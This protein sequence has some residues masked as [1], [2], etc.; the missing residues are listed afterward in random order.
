MMKS[1]GN[2]KVKLSI[3]TLGLIVLIVTHLTLYLVFDFNIFKKVF[4]SFYFEQCCVKGVY[5]SLE[6]KGEI[7]TIESE[8][9]TT[10]IRLTEIDS[11]YILNRYVKKN[12]KKIELKNIAKN[13][14]M[15]YKEEQDSLLYLITDYDDTIR[16]NYNLGYRPWES[17]QVLV[18]PAIVMD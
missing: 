3:G 14:M 12:E 2:K 15:F 4:G 13:G 11:I 18:G 7:E 1:L 5:Y 8:R 10:R 9:G 16:I 6:Y 17:R